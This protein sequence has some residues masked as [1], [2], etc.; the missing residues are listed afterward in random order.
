M[1]TLEHSMQEDWPILNSYS[2]PRRDM[3][4]YYVIAKFNTTMAVNSMFKCKKFNLTKVN[5]IIF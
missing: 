2:E 4:I 1:T 3:N 5:E